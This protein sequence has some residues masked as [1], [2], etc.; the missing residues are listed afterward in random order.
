MRSGPPKV[1]TDTDVL[2]YAFRGDTRAAPFQ[3]Y[4]IGS[5]VHISFMTVAELEQWTVARN[6]GAMRQAQLHTF[7]EQFVIVYV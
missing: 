7:I 5:V 4:I 2:S 6:W 3:P 1:L